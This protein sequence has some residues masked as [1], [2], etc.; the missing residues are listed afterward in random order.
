MHSQLPS[1]LAILPPTDYATRD[2]E[3]G[4]LFY[5]PDTALDK[6]DVAHMT[7]KDLELYLHRLNATLKYLKATLSEVNDQVP[8]QRDACDDVC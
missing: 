5:R 7:T 1:P 4:N 2:F 6:M 3:D 8:T